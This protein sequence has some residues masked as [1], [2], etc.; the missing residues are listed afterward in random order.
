M[1]K[2]TW[3]QMLTPLPATGVTFPKLPNLPEP[4]YPHQEYGDTKDYGKG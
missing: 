3:V 1:I 2:Q 4:R